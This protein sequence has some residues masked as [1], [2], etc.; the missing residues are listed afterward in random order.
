[1]AHYYNVYNAIDGVIVACYDYGPQYSIEHWGHLRHRYGAD[2]KPPPLNHWSDVAFL[3]YQHEAAVRGQSNNKLKYIVQ[4]RT[5]NVQT[6][7]MLLKIFN[8][9][10]FEK[11]PDWENR[12]IFGMDTEAGQAILGSPN[13]V[14]VAWLLISHKHVWA[15]K[16]IKSVTIYVDQGQAGFQRKNQCPILIFEVEDTNAELA[17]GRLGRGNARVKPSNN[18]Q[19]PRG[20]GKDWTGGEWYGTR[21]S[22][23]AGEHV[24]SR[25]T[26]HVRRSV[27]RH[28]RQIMI[29]WVGVC[30]SRPV[31]REVRGHDVC[32]SFKLCGHHSPE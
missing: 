2:V 26:D 6:R 15:N 32:G 23:R 16:R 29:Q 8:L 18:K 27:N 20:G 11:F 1:M 14:G 31:P 17:L 24:S 13:G 12:Q 28:C 10:E 22:Q 9:R 7:Q 19:L 4:A 5:K 30:H 25:G 21:Y 3:T